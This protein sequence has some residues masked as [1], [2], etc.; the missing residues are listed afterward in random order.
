[1]INYAFLNIFIEYFKHNNKLEF[2]YFILR[3]SLITSSFCRL[4]KGFNSIVE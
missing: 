2:L 4:P 3:F 1:M